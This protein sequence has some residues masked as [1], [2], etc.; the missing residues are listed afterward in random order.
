MSK[1]RQK[2]A[3]GIYEGALSAIDKYKEKNTEKFIIFHGIESIKESN[4]LL[5]TLDKVK[6][7]EQFTI[8]EAYY[9]NGRRCCFKKCLFIAE[10]KG[11]RSR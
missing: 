1:L 3:T 7:F 11:I 5:K 10:S 4:R 6:N 9:I 8:N 2:I